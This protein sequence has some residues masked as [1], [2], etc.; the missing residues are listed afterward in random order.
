MG[1]NNI[2]FQI[3][4]TGTTVLGWVNQAMADGKITLSEA[5]DLVEQLGKIWN[6][7]VELEIPAP[8]SLEKDLINSDKYVNSKTSY[9]LPPKPPIVE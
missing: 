7:K 2:F 9:E 1:L 4:A 3:M 6:F 5:V 8:L